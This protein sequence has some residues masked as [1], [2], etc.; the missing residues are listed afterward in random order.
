MIVLSQKSPHIHLRAAVFLHAPRVSDLR[1]TEADSHPHI[2]II[3]D[4]QKR[5]DVRHHIQHI[6]TIA[7]HD[8][9]KSVGAAKELEIG[10]RYIGVLPPAAF[11]C[12]SYGDDAAGA[13]LDAETAACAFAGIYLQFSYICHVRLLFS[14]ALSSGHSLSSFSKCRVCSFLPEPSRTDSSDC[15]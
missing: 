7:H 12:S 9:S 14:D 3:R 15:Q 4:I 10:A 5:S 1:M 8:R 11:P 6:Q 2:V 13:Y